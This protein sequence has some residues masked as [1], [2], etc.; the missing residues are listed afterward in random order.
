MTTP[1]RA[2]LLRRIARRLI[3][4]DDLAKEVDTSFISKIVSFHWFWW[5]LSKMACQ[6]TTSNFSMFSKCRTSI[7]SHL[8]NFRCLSDQ[9]WQESKVA[10]LPGMPFKKEFKGSWAQSSRSP[11]F[12][13]CFLQKQQ[14]WESVIWESLKPWCY[15]KRDAPWTLTL[16]SIG[17]TLAALP[18]SLL[19]HH[20]SQEPVAAPLGSLFLLCSRPQEDLTAGLFRLFSRDQ[21]KLLLNDP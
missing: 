14:F 4:A 19:W 15:L 20:W 18:G 13:Y 9:S 17:A 10:H 1:K 3:S 6:S 5:L 2:F 11:I 12:S 21:T 16:S 8:T 7:V